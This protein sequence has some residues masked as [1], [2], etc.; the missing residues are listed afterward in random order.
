MML[1]PVRL[2]FGLLEYTYYSG[3]VKWLLWA[4]RQWLYYRWPP[5]VSIIDPN[6]PLFQSHR[7]I[8]QAT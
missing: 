4:R 3:R 6:S 2:H 8:S 1:H 7:N 5:R